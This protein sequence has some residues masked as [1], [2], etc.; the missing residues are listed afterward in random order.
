MLLTETWIQDSILN[1]IL[2]NEEEEWA[3]S[4]VSDTL[5]TETAPNTVGTAD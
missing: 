4:T 5:M 2:N 3:L 1:F